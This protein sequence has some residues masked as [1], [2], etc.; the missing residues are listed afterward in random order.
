MTW[1]TYEPWIRMPFGMRPHFHNILLLFIN[2]SSREKSF[3]LQIVYI[4]ET[5]KMCIPFYWTVFRAHL[6]AKNKCKN[7]QAISYK[8]QGARSQLA[9]ITARWSEN[10]TNNF[11]FASA[12]SCYCCRYCVPC[13]TVL[14]LLLF[15][16]VLIAIHVPVAVELLVLFFPCRKIAIFAS[17]VHKSKN[18]QLI[19]VI[20]SKNN[21]TCK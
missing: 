4:L 3:E 20:S 19:N 12:I 1:P 18:I 7:A 2:N 15:R 11:F 14:L 16:S 5:A 21:E 17:N 6:N 8:A 9:R 13:D 10:L